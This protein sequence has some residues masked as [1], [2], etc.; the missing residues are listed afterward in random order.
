[1]AGYGLLR[2]VR[3]IDRRRR[4]WVYTADDG[5]AYTKSQLACG[6][7]RGKMPSE[8]VLA[9]SEQMAHRLDATIV[10]HTEVRAIDRA[11]HRL[12]TDRGEH[13]YGQLVLA[14]GACPVRPTPLRGSAAS[15]V[16]TL[17]SLADYRYFRSELDGR[18][19]VVVLGGGL[20]GCEFAEGLLRAGCDVTLFEAGSRL[21]GDKLPGLCAA[22]VARALHSAGVCVRLED[23]VHSVEQALDELELTTL[24]GQHLAADLVVAALGTRPRAALA[25]DAGLAVGH[26][27]IVDHQLRTADPD[28]FAVGECVELGG[29]L[30]TLSEDIEAAARVLAAVLTGAGARIG[31]QP[32]MQRLQLECCPAVLCEPPP[33]AGEWQESATRKGVRAVF[34]DR[35]GALRGFALVGEPIGEAARLYGQLRR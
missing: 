17:A 15:Q 25:R 23:G 32:R 14:L 33:I 16:L 24:S 7:A 8:L 1:M 21:A 19:R 5:C 2:S 18:R 3:H 10:T 35:R 9:T 27:I 11:R 28:I 4:V 26:G 12:I 34:H 29:R 6:L 20:P 13:A 22:R 31:W 30:F